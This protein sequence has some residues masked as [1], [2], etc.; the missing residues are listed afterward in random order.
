MKAVV[1]RPWVIEAP[2]TYKRRN[3]CGDKSGG[4]A[5]EF[6]TGL[7]STRTI[8]QKPMPAIK[9]Y[10]NAARAAQTDAHKLIVIGR[11]ISTGHFKVPGVVDNWLYSQMT[12]IMG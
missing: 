1:A 4:G 5:F 7:G 2:L 10:V 12:V 8:M 6:G 3:W 11:I 9:L